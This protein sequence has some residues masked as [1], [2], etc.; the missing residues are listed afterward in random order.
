MKYIRK[1]ISNILFLGFIIFLFTPYGLPVRATL[2]KGVTF[3]TTRVFSLEIDKED[4][5]Q[6]NDYDWI[7]QATDGSQINMQS[8]KNKVVLVNFWATW[9]PPCVAEMPSFQSLYNDYGDKVVFLFIANDDPEKVNTFLEN[10]GYDLPVFF[11][12]SGVPEAMNSNSL[13]TT[14]IINSSGSIVVSKVG[15]ADWDSNRVRALLDR[16]LP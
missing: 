11:Q 5:K 14:Y 2:I 15:A 10:K 3:I 7:L 13:P 12:A 6:L 9:C 8:L 16:Q 1:N 4:Q